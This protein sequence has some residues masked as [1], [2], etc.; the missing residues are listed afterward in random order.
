MTKIAKVAEHL[1]R[2]KNITSWEAITKYRATRL[3]DMVYQLKGRGWQIGTTM[4]ENK[5]GIRFA[6]YVLLKEPKNGQ[7]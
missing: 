6:R 4:V 7:K 5:D 1:R 3:A 2:Y